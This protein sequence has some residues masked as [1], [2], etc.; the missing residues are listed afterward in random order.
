MTTRNRTPAVAARTLLPSNPN[1]FAVWLL[2]LFL[3]LEYVRPWFL[4]VL[5]LQMVII[6]LMVILWVMG[7]DRPWS[8][9]LTAQVLFFILCLQAV[10]FA[11]NNYA[12]Y[13]TTRVMFGH[14][15]I[16]LGLSWL[17]TTLSTF[18][19]VACAWLL[20]MGYIAGYGILHDGRGPGAMVG[21]ENDL[22]LGCATAF[23]FAFH[24][25]E[26][27]SGARRWL[28]GAI[29]GLLVVAIVVSFSRGGFVALVVV[30]LFCWS[31]SRHKV[32]WS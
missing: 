7:R 27:F 18:R 15:S 17:L 22:A 25:F 10:P 1:N 31:A 6:I 32:R 2:I 8:G 11:W 14:V 24:G 19:R 21:D 28:W 12:A 30:G 20:I 26:R 16:A 29:G 23:A 4:A 3:V 13:E 5:R 9:I